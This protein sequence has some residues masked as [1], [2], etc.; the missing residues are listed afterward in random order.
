MNCPTLSLFPSPNSASIPQLGLGTWKAEPKLVSNIVSKAIQSGYRAIDCACDYGNEKFVGEG[1]KTG[2]ETTNISR[3][4]LFITSKLWN[5]YHKPDHVGPACVKSLK[6]LGLDYL[7]MYMIHFPI[8]LKFVPFEKRYPPEWIHDSENEATS[9]IV[10]EKVPLRDTWR[11]M[12]ALVDEGLVRHLGVCNFPFALLSDLLSYAKIRPSVL[13]IEL[14]PYLQQ[15][16]LLKFCSSENI[17][18][19]AFS[20]FGATSYKSLG[21][22]QGHDLFKDP[23]LV[24][25]ASAHSKTVA[26]VMLKWAV[27]RKTAVIPKTSQSQR[28]VENM[29]IFDWELSQEDMQKIAKMDKGIRY[30]D[31]GQFCVGMGMSIPIYD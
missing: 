15:N 19:T 22:D 13:Q 4:Q 26:Q 10:T 31:P 28:L 24:A 9:K 6:D 27:Q 18:V 23:T 21:M 20:S 11:A 30:N 2:I 7:D 12:E 29:S 3:K 8:S 25:I 1:I 5:T 16:R 14:H 17:V